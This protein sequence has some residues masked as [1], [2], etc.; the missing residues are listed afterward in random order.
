MSVNHFIFDVRFYTIK[1]KL[2]IIRKYYGIC[3][4]ISGGA[5]VGEE[6]IREA[7]SR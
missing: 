1:S 2:I 5:W 6:L 7:F 3:L 4:H